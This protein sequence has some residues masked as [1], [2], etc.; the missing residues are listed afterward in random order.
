MKNFPTDLDFT[1]VRRQLTVYRQLHNLL[2][3]VIYLVVFGVGALIFNAQVQPDFWYG[4]SFVPAAWM[5]VYYVG[6]FI[7][8]PFQVRVHGYAEQSDDVLIRSG[9]VFRRYD[10]VP[11]GRLQFVEVQ[12]GP[13]QRVFDLAH[14]TITTAGSTATIYG[15]P[16]REATRLRDDL[17]SR[18]YAR[19]AG[20]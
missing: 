15:L 4:W 7:I 10:A 20:L 18:G 12:Q 1:P 9:A 5:V 14:V 6:V 17:S 16:T 13:L 19:L 11:Y 2:N 8:T 3:L